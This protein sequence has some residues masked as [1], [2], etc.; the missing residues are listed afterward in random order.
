MKNRGFTLIELLVVIAII[1]ILAAI[2]LPALARAREAAR[3]ASCQNNLKQFGIVY[4]MYSGESK[5]GLW[6]R[7]QEWSCRPNDHLGAEYIPNFFQIYPEYLTDPA[8]SLCPSATTGNDVA[9]VYNYIEDKI[10]DGDLTDPPTIVIN[11]DGDTALT[12]DYEGEFFPCEPWNGTESYLYVGWS[13]DNTG[14]SDQPDLGEYTNPDKTAAA[15]ALIVN[16]YPLVATF[17]ATYVTGEM[18]K[19][20][21][22]DNGRLDENIDVNDMLAAAGATP[23]PTDLQVLRLR[24]GIERFYVTDINNPAG[25]AKGQSTI[26]VMSDWVSTDI[27]QEFNHVPGGSNVLYMDGH[28]EFI[29]YPTKWPINAQMAILQGEELPDALGL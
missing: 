28:V 22:S 12:P 7:Q 6:P 17:I 21:P 14:I 8:V 9:E 23:L 19:G 11:N 10:A 2:L 16:N 1:G 3:R 18:V 25:S 20:D 4:K 29:K 5:G 24:E 26:S 27:G 15:T 13:L